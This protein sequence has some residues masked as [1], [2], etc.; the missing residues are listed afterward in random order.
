MGDGSAEG[1]LVGAGG[2][3]GGVLR[4]GSDK[5]REL[6]GT[7]RGLAEGTL[8]V[9][10]LVSVGGVCGTLVAA[11]LW[12]GEGALM[13]ICSRQVKSVGVT[14]P[15]LLEMLL[16]MAVTSFLR[17]PLE[18]VFHGEECVVSA[19][20]DGNMEFCSCSANSSKASGSVKAKVGSVDGKREGESGTG[21]ECS[22]CVVESG[23]IS[24]MVGSGAGE[25]VFVFHCLS[26]P[27]SVVHR[28]HFEHWRDDLWE[29][30]VWDTVDADGGLS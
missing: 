23:A 9:G 16:M 17:W 29:P 4:G 26:G 6:S 20:S 3:G 27:K 28:S 10:G 18:R 30:S 22:L 13:P 2:V 12:K 14:L 21:S 24:S 19:G 5:Q 11:L 8:P 15:L 25:V 7:K 1:K